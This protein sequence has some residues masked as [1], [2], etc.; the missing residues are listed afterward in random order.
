M[1]GHIVNSCGLILG[2][3]GVI[4]IFVWG[5]PQPNF[6]ESVLIAVEEATVLEDGTKVADIIAEQERLRQQHGSD[7]EWALD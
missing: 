6:D 4:L 7:R 1:V 5:P 2:M 3:A